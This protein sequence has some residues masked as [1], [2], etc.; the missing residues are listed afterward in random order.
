MNGTTILHQLKEVTGEDKSSS[1]KIHLISES[2]NVEEVLQ[3]MREIT[4]LPGIKFQFAELNHNLAKIPNDPREDDFYPLVIYCQDNIRIYVSEV[5][6][7][8]RGASTDATIKILELIGAELSQQA[9]E[10]IY[11]KRIIAKRMFVIN[12]DIK[13]Y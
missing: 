7:G 2:G 5:R 1:K 3:R 8:Y 10:E 13:R 11:N 12:P 9:K 4:R 6:C